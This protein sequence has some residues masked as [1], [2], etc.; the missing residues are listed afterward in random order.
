MTDL[1]ER[2]FHRLGTQLSGRLSSLVTIIM[3]HHC[4]LGKAQTTPL[5]G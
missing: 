4:D 2:R 3:H 1:I 5:S